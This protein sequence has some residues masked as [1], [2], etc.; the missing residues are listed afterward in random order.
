MAL[1]DGFDHVDNMGGQLG[2]IRQGLMANLFAVAVASP[3]QHRLVAAH[4][5]LLIHMGT[6]CTGYM[7]RHRLDHTSILPV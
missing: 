4:V 2:Q 5:A 6:R 7:H 3:H 1:E